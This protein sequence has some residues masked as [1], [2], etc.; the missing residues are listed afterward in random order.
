MLHL[1]S[2]RDNYLGVCVDGYG[3]GQNVS[4]TVVRVGKTR[5]TIEVALNVGGTVMRSVL[6]TSLRVKP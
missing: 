1:I 6:P 4:A 3:F 2:Y 5:V